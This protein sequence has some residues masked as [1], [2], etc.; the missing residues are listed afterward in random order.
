MAQRRLYQKAYSMLKPEKATPELVARLEIALQRDEINQTQADIENATHHIAYWRKEIARLEEL[1][2]KLTRRLY[3]QRYIL[4]KLEMAQNVDD[5]AE[6][7][8]NN[9]TA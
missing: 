1:R 3:N 2:R 9:M 4:R 7:L 5:D 6:F 8:V